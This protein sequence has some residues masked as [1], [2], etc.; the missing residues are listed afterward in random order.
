VGGVKM[1]IDI[2]QVVSNNLIIIRDA[3]RVVGIIP[4]QNLIDAHLNS[5]KLMRKNLMK[6][7]IGQNQLIKM[8]KLQK[9][10]QKKIKEMPFQKEVLNRKVVL[11]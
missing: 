8:N 5:L 6:I 2:Y 1:I 4:K 9:K 11:K 7:L 3:L 10:Q